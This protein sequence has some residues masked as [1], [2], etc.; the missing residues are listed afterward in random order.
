MSDKLQ[1]VAR[2]DKL[3]LVGLQIEALPAGGVSAQT[4]F[5]AI[6]PTNMGANTNPMA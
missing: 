2:N 6:E 5:V 4:L 3:K 1:F